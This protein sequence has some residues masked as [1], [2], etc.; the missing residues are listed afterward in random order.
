LARLIGINF[1]RPSTF[2]DIARRLPAVF[3]R[4]AAIAAEQTTAVQTVEQNLVAKIPKLL[5]LPGAAAPV[6]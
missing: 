6:R 2:H 1:S 5:A 4:M 3:K